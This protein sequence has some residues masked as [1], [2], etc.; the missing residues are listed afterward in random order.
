MRV[1]YKIARLELSNLFF[2]PVAWFLLVVLVFITGYQFTGRL[3][4]LSRAQAYGSSLYAL[5]GNLFYGLNGLW[6]TMKQILYFAMPLLTMGLISQEYSLGSIKLLYSSPISTRQIVVGKYMGIMFYGL[7]V[8]LLLCIPV[9]VAAVVVEN[10]EWQAV[11]TGLL[12]LYLL[13]GLYSAIGLFMSALTNYQLVSA[14]CMLVML[15]ILKWVSGIGQEY[16]FI[17]DITYWLS[18]ESRVDNFIKGLICSEDVLYFVILSA[19]FVSFAVLKMQLKRE[20]HAMWGKI[21]RYV[22]VFVAAMLLGYLTSRPMVKFYCDSTYTK[23]NT[24]SETSQEIVNALDGGMTITTYSNLLGHDYRLT[25]RNVRRDMDRYENFLRFKP[26]MKLKYV[27]YYAAD[28]AS[29]SFKHYHGNKTVDEA[30][31]Y[32]TELTGDKIQWYLTPAEIAKNTE[33]AERGYKFLCI[34]EREN[35]QKEY[36]RAFNDTRRLPSEKEIVAVLRRFI[37]PAPRIGFLTTNTT[38]S[39]KTRNNEDYYTLADE[40]HRF[41]LVNQGFDVFSVSLEKD[42]SYILDSLDVL[43]VSDPEGPYAAEDMETLREYVRRGKNLILAVKPASYKYL[44]PLTSDL[45]LVFEPGILVETPRKDVP[46]NVVSC[47]IPLNS[48]AGFSRYFNTRQFANYTAPGASAIDVK[49]AGGFTYIPTLVTKDKR[50]WNE[51]KTIDFI[52]ERATADTTMGEHPGEKTV[53]VSLKR[54][55]ANGEREQ[56]IVVMGDADLISLGELGSSRRGVSSANGVLVDGIFGWLVYDELPLRTGHPAPIDNRLELSMGGASALTVA[57][58]WGLPA[59][60]LCLG[61]M[62]L[63]R[64]KKK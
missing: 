60:I 63:V 42:R 52:N 26:E 55:A 33:V 20:R 37:K 38:R 44:E 29:A 53:M 51:L 64:R 7:L 9:A 10:F 1:I 62:S 27:F 48:E 40:G 30:A 14:I 34:V 50:A 59:V 24:L 61:V 5:S 25:P 18:I 49:G 8:M 28:T 43:M 47:E 3:E 13:W 45:G 6:G 4:E 11:L 46:A 54:L 12:G 23:A 35:G 57:L 39:I 32:T 19:M 21:V 36:L 16:P 2:S 56:R 41:S 17:R 22:G 15:Y 58:K 31:R